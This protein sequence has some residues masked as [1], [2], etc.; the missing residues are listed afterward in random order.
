M[1][2][3]LATIQDHPL[4]PVVILIIFIALFLSLVLMI[5]RKHTTQIY[6]E[7]S[8]MPLSDEGANNE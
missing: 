8:K 1:K 6:D 2:Q 3:M 7:V 4:I 5:Y